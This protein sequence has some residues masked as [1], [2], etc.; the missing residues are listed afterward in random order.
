M[1]YLKTLRKF[2][3]ITMLC[4]LILMLYGYLVRS[5]GINFFWES[6]SLGF[7]LLLIGLISLL[8]DGLRAGKEKDKKIITILTKIGI[9][10]IVFILTVR[11]ILVIVIPNSAAYSV[12]KDYIKNNSEL[13]NELG[14]IKAFGLI[15]TGGIQVS[16]D[17]NGEQGS[18]SL[19]MIIKG[20]K[21][22]RE[23]TVFL[24]KSV[25]SDWKV[26]GI[27]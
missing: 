6:K 5:A 21:K 24:N 1:D 20:R 11:I 9:G 13:I 2:T 15:P 19:N 8:A 16:R 18:A 25:D 3:K 23:V 7:A 17:S 26:E 14:E 27:E 10:I 22:Y 12:A 4:G